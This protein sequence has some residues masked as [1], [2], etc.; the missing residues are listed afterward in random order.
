M[1]DLTI[2]KL[3]A[4]EPELSYLRDDVL[5]D[6][7]SLIQNRRTHPIPDDPADDGELDRL[8]ASVNAEIIARG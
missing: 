7:K 4:M 3:R 1:S 2:R 8:E 5:R 6:A